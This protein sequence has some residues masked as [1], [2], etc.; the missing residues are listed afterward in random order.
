MAEVVSYSTSL[1][2]DQDR[3]A[4]ALYLKSRDASPT[5][6]PQPADPAAMRRGAA[7]Y[8]DACASCHLENGVGS[9]ASSRRSA[10]TPW[11]SR[12]IRPASST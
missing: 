1:M 4:I 11:S 3:R 12:P 8:S 5:A 6:A 9:R 2:T 10:T 7:I